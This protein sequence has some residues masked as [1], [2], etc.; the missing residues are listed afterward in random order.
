MVQYRPL[1]HN[2]ML[3]YRQYVLS[4]SMDFLVHIIH[5]FFH[6]FFYTKFQ[7]NNIQFTYKCWDTHI[8]QKRNTIWNCKLKMFKSIPEKK[9]NKVSVPVI[10]HVPKFGHLHWQMNRSP[11]YNAH[12]QL[13]WKIS[14]TVTLLAY[15]SNI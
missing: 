8:F 13:K 3:H 2:V 5:I 4:F 6:W 10:G 7:S 15:E 11:I 1:L 14:T 12:K 9:L